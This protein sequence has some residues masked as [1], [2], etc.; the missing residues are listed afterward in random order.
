MTAA[1]Y[2]APGVF[3]SLVN[4]PGL[5]SSQATGGVLGLIANF[6]TGPR[7]PGLTYTSFAQFKRDYGDPAGNGA[8]YSGPLAAQL[9]FTQTGGGSGLTQ[10]LVARRA[11]TTLATLT[12]V[13]TSLSLT[14][15]AT[16]K[17][18]GTAGNAISVVVAAES[19]SNQTITLT[20]ANNVTES[21]TEPVG[22]T[23]ATNFLT[24]INQASKMVT[25]SAPTD[26]ANPFTAG[27]FTPSGGTDGKNAA[28]V[29]AD[30]D[31][32]GNVQVNGVCAMDGTLATAQLLQTHVETNSASYSKPRIGFA[33]P[34]LGTSVSTIE[35]NAGVTL[36]TADGRMVYAGH[37]GLVM[38]NPVTN[39]PVN[40]DGSYWAPVAAGVA[41]SRSV[42]DPSTWK[43]VAGVLG[44]VNPQ[45][46]ATLTALSQ[47]GC[48]VVDVGFNGLVCKDAVTTT[49]YSGTVMGKLVNRTA[50]DEFVRRAQFWAATQLI[51]QRNGPDVPQRIISG[52]NSVGQRAVLDLVIAS[53]D[54]VAPVAN[55]TNGYN[56]NCALHLLGEVDSVNIPIT[57]LTS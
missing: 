45:S 14:L 6:P 54:S 28:I 35:N 16:Q 29:Q 3:P 19:G 40:L 39:S 42:S 30:F 33:G 47:N 12:L 10:G 49:N 18:A 22:T 5:G 13:G 41:F 48:W 53:L 2:T 26:S 15:T 32:M 27:T 44:P 11:G 20:D 55:G 37:D 57:I 24:A 8:G 51:G 36:N 23:T 31:A 7:D 34:A 1:P 17:Y 25:A 38:F 43:P 50:L 56:V 52:F 21:Y 4:S 9:F 46:E